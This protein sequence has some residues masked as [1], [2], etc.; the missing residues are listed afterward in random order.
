MGRPRYEH[1]KMGALAAKKMKE[2]LANGE[3]VNCKKAMMEVGYTENSAIQNSAKQTESF[4]NEMKDILK[5]MEQ[6]RDKA[7]EKMEKVRDD[8]TYRDLGDVVNKLT[9]QIQLLSGRSTANDTVNFVW[10]GEEE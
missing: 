2:Q 7:L 4:K 9:N 8:A 6:E 3:R 10:K 5:R 1:L